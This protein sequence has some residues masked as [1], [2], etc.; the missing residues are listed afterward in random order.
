MSLA[1]NTSKLHPA[2]A[3]CAVL[4]ATSP[5]LR[6]GASRRRQ[7]AAAQVFRRRVSTV[8]AALPPEMPPFDHRPR[9]Y[10]GMGGAEILDK[11]KAFL[12]SSLFCYYQ[13]P[14]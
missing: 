2:A 5:L 6:R 7:C 11:R 8:A 12:G 4:A 10:A 9:P 14:V 1:T 3:A 13:K